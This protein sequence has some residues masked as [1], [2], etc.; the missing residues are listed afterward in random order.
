VPV[1]VAWL[2]VQTEQGRQ[3]H[4]DLNGRTHPLRPRQQRIVQR[5][6]A[7]I[8]EGVRA[9]LVGAARIGRGGDRSQRVDGPHERGSALGG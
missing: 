7:E 5:S 2:I 4:R 3:R 6:H 8:D 1:E 9:A